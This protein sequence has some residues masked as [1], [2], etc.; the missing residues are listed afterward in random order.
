VI[1]LVNVDGEVRAVRRS[2]RMNT[3]SH[4][5]VLEVLS[6][7]TYKFSGKARNSVNNAQLNTID[8]TGTLD[9]S[10]L[11][12]CKENEA[13][14]LEMEEVNRISVPEEVLQIHGFAP[15]KKGECSVCLIY[16]NINGINTRLCENG[17]V[18]RMKEIHDELEVDLAAY[19]EHKIKGG[20]LKSMLFW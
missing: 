11:N 19:C 1:K 7:R 13:L 15:P 12:I 18:E 6:H 5:S 3:T 8:D 17:K 14:Q 2:G 9:L 4:T 20:L 10:G 16:E